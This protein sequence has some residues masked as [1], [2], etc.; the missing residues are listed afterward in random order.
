MQRLQ[1]DLAVDPSCIGVSVPQ[2][3]SNLGERGA[4][5]EHLSGQS[6]SKL[7]GAV[8]GRGVNPRTPEAMANNRPNAT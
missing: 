6:M 1:I 4:L 5:A 2:H 3:R 8:S 7:V